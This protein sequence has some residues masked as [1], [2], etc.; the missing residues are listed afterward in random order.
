[1]KYGALSNNLG[2]IDVTWARID[3]GEPRLRLSWRETGGPAVKAPTRAGFGSF[4]LQRVLSEDLSGE[5][6]VRFEPAGVCC[7]LETPLRGD[8]G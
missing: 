3:A 4:L 2:R 8:A 7:L 5:V 1:M 6:N